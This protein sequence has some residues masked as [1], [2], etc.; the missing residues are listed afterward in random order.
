MS[1]YR[2]FSSFEPQG[3][4]LAYRLR[5]CFNLFLGWIIP[6]KIIT[7]YRRF[8]GLKYENNERCLLYD[9]SATRTHFLGLVVRVISLHSCNLTIVF[10]KLADYFICTN[11]FV[12]AFRH[13]PMFIF[14]KK[15]F[16]SCTRWCKKK[17]FLCRNNSWAI[18]FGQKLSSNYSVKL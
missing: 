4:K 18:D 1:V 15:R 3:T 9:T 14:T 13:K 8:R 5:G 7:C 12:K 11:F 17:E 2:L 10:C 6:P 16:F